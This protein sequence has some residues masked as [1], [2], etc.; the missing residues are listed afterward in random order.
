MDCGQYISSLA[1]HQCTSPLDTCLKD[2]QQLF[3]A[4]TIVALH[5]N[6]LATMIRNGVQTIII[7]LQQYSPSGI[8]TRISINYKWPLKV[9][10]FQYRQIAQ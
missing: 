6:I 4:P 9:R 2:R 3:F 10:Q 1:H 7:L 8:L 5:Q